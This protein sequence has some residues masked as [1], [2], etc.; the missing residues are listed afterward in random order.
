[1]M[2]MSKSMMKMMMM[3]KLIASI[4]QL[5][6][7]LFYTIFICAYMYMCVRVLARVCVFNIAAKATATTAAAVVNRSS[8]SSTSNSKYIY[9]G[10]NNIVFPPTS[11]SFI[12]WHIRTK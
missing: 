8:R 7:Y 6:I 11:S 9:S 4:V 10:F 5:E 3:P 1:M 12:F 2:S